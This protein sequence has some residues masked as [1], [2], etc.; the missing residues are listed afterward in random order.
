MGAHSRHGRSTQSL[1]KYCVAE[2]VCFRASAVHWCLCPLRENVKCALSVSAPGYPSGKLLQSMAF[3]MS[4]PAFQ[5]IVPSYRFAALPKAVRALPRRCSAGMHSPISVGGWLR[6]VLTATS[7]PCTQL[8]SLSKQ[9]PL[10][11]VSQ[12]ASDVDPASAGAQ[13]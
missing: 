12:N 4:S 8:A 6:V 1:A 3:N 2:A 7:M 9:T 5:D 13:P 10:M 11:K